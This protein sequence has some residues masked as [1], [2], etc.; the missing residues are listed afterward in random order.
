M[1]LC[2]ALINYFN[3]PVKLNELNT[4]H[5]R[6]VLS[7][8]TLKESYPSFVVSNVPADELAPSSA[9]AWP[10][11]DV[12][13]HNISIIVF[14]ITGNWTVCKKLVEINNKE[15][16]KHHIAGTLWGKSTII[17]GIPSQRAGNALRHPGKQGWPNAGT[18][19]TAIRI[20]SEGLWW[21]TYCGAYLYPK[22]LWRVFA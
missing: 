11:A 21:C 9:S 17:S 2:Y 8:K 5:V 1:F 3:W 22:F 14:Q 15:T 4:L 16:S 10:S 19:E 20:S 12:Q 7:N 6:V 18:V 13:W